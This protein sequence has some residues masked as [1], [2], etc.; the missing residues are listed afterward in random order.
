MIIVIFLELKINNLKIF[1]LG[2]QGGLF[3]LAFNDNFILNRMEKILK[4]NF[5]DWEVNNGKEKKAT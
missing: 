1:K 2:L 3:L 4:I 5:M